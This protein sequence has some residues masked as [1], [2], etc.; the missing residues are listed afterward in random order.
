MGAPPHAP[1][2]SVPPI[3]TPSWGVMIESARGERSREPVVWWKLVAATGSLFGLVLSLNLFGDAPRRA[4]D[5]KR[6]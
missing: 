6:G 3:G 5:P 2:A 4:F 1:S